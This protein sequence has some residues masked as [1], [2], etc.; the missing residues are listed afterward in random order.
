M[1]APATPAAI[2][3]PCRPGRPRDPALDD[4]ILDAAMALF[5][6]GGYRGVTIEGVAARA[7]VGKASIYRRYDTRAELVVE[8]IR[9]RMCLIH[10]LADTGDL[11]ADLLALLR[12][13][14]DRLR[15]PE[16]PVLTALM[17]ERFREPELAAEFERSVV[18]RKREHV[19][20]I[21]DAAIERGELPADTDVELLA[22]A[23]AAIVWHHALNNLPIE[24]GFAARVVDYVL[25]RAVAAVSGR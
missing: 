20:R 8:A 4:A 24:E 12:P 11:R 2:D 5:A 18:G 13:L 14:V 7:G 17:A 19:R 1:N 3:G 10:D 6:E 15:T 9:T 16:G 22:E 25:G 23:P 21:I